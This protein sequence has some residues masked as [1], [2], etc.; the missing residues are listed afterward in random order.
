MDGKRRAGPGP[1]VPPKRARGG[2]WDEDDVLRPSQFEEELALMEEMEAEHRLQER[3][4]EGLQPGLEGA[5]D[6][7]FSPTTIDAR[8]L[9]PAPP[10]LDPQTEP[11][12]FQQLE[13]DHYVGEFGG[14]ARWVAG[15]TRALRVEARPGQPLWLWGG[16]CH[17]HLPRARA[18]PCDPDLLPG[19]ALG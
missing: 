10:P 19:A 3:E 17:R 4:E 13:I 9:R 18:G 15:G 11:L 6:G 12:I 7:Q 8:W 16:D 1:G 2:L 5:A 14:Q